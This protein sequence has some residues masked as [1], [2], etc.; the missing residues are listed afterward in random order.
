MFCAL[1]S[2]VAFN[3]ICLLELLP[4]SKD[5]N[6]TPINGQDIEKCFCNGLHMTLKCRNTKIWPIFVGASQCF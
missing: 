6:C 1:F 3:Y 2:F 5:R 4:Y